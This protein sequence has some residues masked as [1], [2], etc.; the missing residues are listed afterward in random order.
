M[1]WWD[2][3]RDGTKMVCWRA[4]RAQK[5][6]GGGGLRGIGLM[7]DSITLSQALP[8]ACETVNAH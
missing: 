2:H 5:S 3:F 1:V 8:H 7:L 4:L 6:P